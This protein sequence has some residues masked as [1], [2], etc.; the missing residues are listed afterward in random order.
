[1]PFS[2]RY[3]CRCIPMH[4]FKESS[5]LKTHPCI[6]S[7][8]SSFMHAQDV[9]DPRSFENLNTWKAE[10]LRQVTGSVADVGFPFIV[11]GNK[12]DRVGLWLAACTFYFVFRAAR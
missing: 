2:L 6:S 12:M 1:M 3:V 5:P 4:T 8:L 7:L 9:T 10:F 11:L